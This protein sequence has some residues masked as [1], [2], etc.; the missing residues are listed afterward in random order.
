[1][2]TDTLITL[3]AGWGALQALATFLTAF[4]PKHTIA[5][6]IAKAISSGAQRPQVSP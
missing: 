2:D 1:M 6:K 3:G 5:F 4:L